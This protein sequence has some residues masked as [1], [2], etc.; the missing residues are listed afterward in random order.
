MVA[1]GV[2][3]HKITEQHTVLLREKTGQRVLPIWIGTDQAHSI[4]VHLAGHH[5][6]R[7]MTHDLVLRLM[8]A[9]GGRF[10][11]A[12]IHTIVPADEGKTG[13]FLADLVATDAAGRDVT[14]DCRPSDAVAIAVRCGAPILVAADLFEK[15]AVPS[16]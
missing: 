3:V 9:L 6:E 15:N 2:T 13:V 1:Q 11:R 7:P 8:E 12:V 14:I 10:A 4:S 5:S 16:I